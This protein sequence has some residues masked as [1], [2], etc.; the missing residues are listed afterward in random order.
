MELKLILTK[1]QGLKLIFVYLIIV[2]FLL[3]EVTRAQ[4]HFCV[5]DNSE[6]LT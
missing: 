1:L 6:I 2:K 5:L 3:D 4:A